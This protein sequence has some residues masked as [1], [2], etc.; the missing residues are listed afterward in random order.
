MPKVKTPEEFRGELKVL[1]EKAE[2]AIGKVEA[3]SQDGMSL[4][5]HAMTKLMRALAKDDSLSSSV[6][7]VK[8]PSK[9]QW[10]FEISYDMSE[11]MNRQ[12]VQEVLK[13]V[14]KMSELLEVVP[15]ISSEG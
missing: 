13:D 12:D 10:V 15:P 14:E 9:S 5:A 7:L 1:K 3:K 8:R 2:R 11:V 4:I 6:R